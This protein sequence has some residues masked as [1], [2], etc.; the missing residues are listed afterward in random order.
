MYFSTLPNSQICNM[1]TI[2]TNK[3]YPWAEHVI[4]LH[5]LL[6]LS[7][8]IRVESGKT[9]LKD[10]VGLCPSCHRATHKFYSS[11]FKKSGLR[12]FGTYTEAQNVYQQAKSEINIV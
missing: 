8:P 10:L 5:H 12:D 4:E 3:R 7:S 1:C 6:P 11:W 9:S 2:D